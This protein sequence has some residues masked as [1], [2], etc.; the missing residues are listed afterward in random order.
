MLFIY[1]W[2][3]WASN[4][5]YYYYYHI[6]LFLISY[7]FNSCECL[8]FSIFYA[9]FFHDSAAYALD[10]ARAWVSAFSALIRLFS[11]LRSRTYFSFW[12]RTFLKLLDSWTYRVYSRLLRAWISL[13]WRFLE[14]SWIF[15][16]STFLASVSFANFCQ[17][18]ASVDFWRSF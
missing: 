3:Y 2:Y 5:L 4:I 12:S 18:I 16:Y 14:F 11:A 15:S 9:S 8:I 13:I 10:N 6:S 17:K 1:Y 7:S